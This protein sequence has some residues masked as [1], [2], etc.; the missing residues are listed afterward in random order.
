MILALWLHGFWWVLLV[1]LAFSRFWAWR[2]ML[3]V[4]FAGVRGLI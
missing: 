3:P 2:A 1:V 4:G